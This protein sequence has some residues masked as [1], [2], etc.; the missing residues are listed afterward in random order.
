MDACLLDKWTQQNNFFVKEWKLSD[1]RIGGN[2]QQGTKEKCHMGTVKLLQMI[3]GV[4][5]DIELIQLELTVAYNTLVFSFNLS[6]LSDVQDNLTNT[7]LRAHEAVGCQTFTR[8]PVMLWHATLKSFSDTA[9]LSCLHNL[10]CV[11]WALLLASCQMKS[12]HQMLRDVTQEEVTVPSQDL[13]AVIQKLRL[14]DKENSNILVAITAREFKDLLQICTVLVEGL[15]SL[16]QENYSAALVAFLEAMSLPAP[17]ALLAQVHTL[18]GFA[19]AKLN[20]PQSAL[21]SYRKALE[22]DFGCHSALYQSALV[23]RQLKNTQAEIEALRLLHLALVQHAE[24]PMD[25][26]EVMV[27]SPDV[28]LSSTCMDSVLAVPATQLILHC[29]AYT[30]VLHDRISEAVELYL[31]LMSS[32]QSDITQPARHNVLTEGDV[33]FLRV[34]VVYLEA[35]FTLL[36]AKRMWDAI[37]VCEDVITKTMN[38]IPEKLLFDLSEE[39]LLFSMEGRSKSVK[40]ERLENVLWAAAAHYLQGLAYCKMK[41]TKE[42]VSS[43]TRSLNWLAKVSLKSTVVGNHGDWEV[44]M[45][46]LQRL[47][48]LA[49]AGRGVSFMERGQL[50]EALRDL[51]LSLQSITDLRMIKFGLVEVY[52]R[53]GRQEEAIACWR[54]PHISAEAFSSGNL[55]LYLQTFPDISLCFDISDLNKM[56]EDAFHRR[57]V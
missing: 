29:L 28:L 10:L 34:A 4:P 16:K 43:F 5:A 25:N 15:E 23:Y 49:L 46:T 17:R 12:I 26:N 6:T 2:Q 52:R 36:R 41:D 45:K 40:H 44:K 47:R 9:H 39:H 42:S 11:Q 50:K 31:D 55:P 27:I 48:G 22:V 24:E 35:A 20:Q 38:L 51:K 19:F 13:R 3:Q 33:S 14:S 53:L 8:D 7:L 32:L 30:C 1:R 57:R 21:Q 56:M 18:T 37:T 54:E